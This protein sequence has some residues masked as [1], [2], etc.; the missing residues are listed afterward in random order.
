MS[1]ENLFFVITAP[2]FISEN[3]T[4]HENAESLSAIALNVKSQHISC[5]SQTLSTVL[6]YHKNP[7]NHLYIKRND[8]VKTI[9]PNQEYFVSKYMG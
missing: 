7:A 2:A 9:F 8:E 6:K 5:E 4:P 3:Q 1:S